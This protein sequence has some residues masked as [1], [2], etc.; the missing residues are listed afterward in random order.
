MLNRS[1]NGARLACLLACCIAVVALPGRAT[2][3][4]TPSAGE[5]AAADANTSVPFLGGFLRETRILYPLQVGEWKAIGEHLYDQPELG[6]SVRYVDATE[7]DKWIDLYFYPAGVISAEEFQK[8][9]AMEREG[10]RQAH[11]Q[12]GVP[13]PEIAALRKFQ[14]DRV[15]FDGDKEAASGWST[16]FEFTLDGQRKSSAMSVMLEQLYF[17]K[18]RF[19]A[20]AS[21]FSR[22]QTSDALETFME[23]LLQRLSI[24][25]TG[26]C[27][28][29]LPIETLKGSQLPPSGEVQMTMDDASGTKVYL[30]QDRVL[31]ADPTDTMASAMMLLGMEQ[32]GHLFPGC[33][34]P[35]PEIPVVPADM[36]EIHLEYTAPA[37]ESK[38]TDAPRLRVRTGAS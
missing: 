11:L 24:N 33:T 20:P 30:L 18:G 38:P 27:W 13:A 6:V 29:P 17:I 31:A 3:A 8:G 36:R 15:M 14:Y 21:K 32:H 23:R 1:R 2:E 5:V 34:A 26:A 25:S 7:Q 16:D 9:V 4:A 37:D 28:M 19:S 12:Q 22:K 10:L 35:N